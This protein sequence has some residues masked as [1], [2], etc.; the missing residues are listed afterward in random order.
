PGSSPSSPPVVL[1]TAGSTA[2][3]PTAAGVAAALAPHVNAAGL[4]NHTGL[5]VVDV[6]SGQTLYGQG[7]ESSMIPA[8]VTKLVTATAV[9]ATRGP[10]YRIQTRAVAGAN[11]GE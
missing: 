4:G 8:S 7:A 11:P 2:P 9:L 1:D 3:A 6:G 5:S 10:A